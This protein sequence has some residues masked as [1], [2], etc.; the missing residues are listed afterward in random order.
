MV[1][2]L[3]SLLLREQFHLHSLLR[4]VCHRIV[5]SLSVQT[6]HF[7][8]ILVLQFQHFTILERCYNAVSY[9]VET[10][11]TQFVCGSHFFVQFFFFFPNFESFALFPWNSAVKKDAMTVYSP[12]YTFCFAKVCHQ[13]FVFRLFQSTLHVSF[14][15]SFIYY[16]W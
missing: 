3:I 14:F 15:F 16:T 8:T 10:I 9:N 5:F 6:H 1:Y 2:T 11:I 7:C 12:I 13:Y 4:H